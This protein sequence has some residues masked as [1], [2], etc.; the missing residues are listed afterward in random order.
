MRKS[1]L[2]V[3]VSLALGGTAVLAASRHGP[4]SPYQSAFNR[5][6]YYR[7]IGREVRRAH[8]V[9]KTVAYPFRY[10]TPLSMATI[11]STKHLEARDAR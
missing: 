5:E 11:C 2:S 1:P 7:M 6:I 3:A 9:G 8:S 10:A 4:V